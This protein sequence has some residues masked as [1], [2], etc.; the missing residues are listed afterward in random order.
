MRIRCLFLLLSATILFA[1]AQRSN[2]TNVQL[3]ER[4]RPSMGSELR[5]KVWTADPAHFETVFNSISSEF[6][7]L[8]GLMSTWKDGSD[9]QSLNKAAGKHPVPVG[10]D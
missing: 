6:D 8:E 10:A 3:V 1:C 9:I 2:S 5:L 4:S 7:R